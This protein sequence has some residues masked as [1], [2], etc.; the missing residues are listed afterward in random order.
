MPPPPTQHPAAHRPIGKAVYGAR[1]G[2]LM[3]EARFIPG[4]TGNALTWPFPVLYK[5][6]RGMSPRRVV[7]EARRGLRD[8]F[9]DAKELADCGAD[10]ITTNCVS[11]QPSEIA[12]PSACRSPLGPMQ[13]PFVERLLLLASASA[14]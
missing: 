4:D 14:S 6:V 1:L 8:A 13:A 11:C 2:I 9:I 5:V 3:L 10:G 7:R 12:R